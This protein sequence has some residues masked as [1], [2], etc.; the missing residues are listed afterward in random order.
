MAQR[1]ASGGREGVGRGERLPDGGS[2]DEQLDEGLEKEKGGQQT[3]ER[4]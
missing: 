4:Y 1:G 3:P 2:L